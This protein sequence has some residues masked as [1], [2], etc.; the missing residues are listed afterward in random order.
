MKK[1]I[2][3]AA[4]VVTA[5]AT[6]SA[7]ASAAPSPKAA[8]V[9]AVSADGKSKT[10]T[11]GASSISANTPLQRASKSTEHELAGSCWNGRTDGG[12]TFYMTCNSRSYHVYVECTDGR[13]LFAETFSG[14]WDFRLTCPAG[15]RAVWGGSW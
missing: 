6:M 4:I 15:T 14:R 7:P 5:F 11:A 2:T 8:E 3:A 1:I 12:R 10:S 9:H 13:H